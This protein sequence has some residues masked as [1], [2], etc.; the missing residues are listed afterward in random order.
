MVHALLEIWRVL[1]PDGSLID[2]RPIHANPPLE[3][4]TATDRL[5]AGHVVDETGGVDDKAADKAMA[6]VVHCGYFT[7][8]MRDSFNCTAY[9]DTLPGLLAYAGKKWR[10]RKRLPPQL[11]DRARHYIDQ[12]DGRTRICITNTIQLAVYQKQET[13]SSPVP[14]QNLS[15]L[16][17]NE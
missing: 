5:R 8:Q 6:D 1:E 16:R 3:V 4:V 9:W 7:T 14:G 12:T 11:L 2:L 17:E 10:D 15:S 13:S